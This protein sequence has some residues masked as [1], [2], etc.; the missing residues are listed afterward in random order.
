MLVKWNKT[1]FLKIEIDRVLRPQ[2]LQA[3]LNQT[4]KGFFFNKEKKAG[5]GETSWES[6][7]SR[8]AAQEVKR[9]L[10]WK[11]FSLHSANFQNEWLKWVVS[12]LSVGLNLELSKCKV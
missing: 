3:F 9:R 2:N 10:Y 4:E 12:H 8:W 7:A 1:G 11:C 6:T 5:R